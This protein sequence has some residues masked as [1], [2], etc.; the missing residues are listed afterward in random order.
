MFN[1][2]ILLSLITLPGQQFTP[3]ISPETEMQGQAICE[4][5]A[6]EVDDAVELGILTSREADQIK[7]MCIVEY[8]AK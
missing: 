4:S 8:Y 7:T 1:F 6:T 2:A 5:V 3:T